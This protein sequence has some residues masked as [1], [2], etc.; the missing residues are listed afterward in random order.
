MTDLGEKT[1]K[2]EHAQELLSNTSSPFYNGTLGHQRKSGFDE[3]ECVTAAATCVNSAC[4]SDLFP[5]QRLG[6]RNEDD[7]KKENV[8]IDA[9]SLRETLATRW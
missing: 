5:S 9:L 6:T 2:I 7:L 8:A 1:A 4:I 3:W